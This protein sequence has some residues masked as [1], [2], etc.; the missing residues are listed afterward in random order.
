MP[1]VRD[2]TT[3]KIQP[4]EWRWPE[5]THHSEG[6]MDTVDSPPLAQPHR[7]YW[8]EYGN[9]KGEPVMFLHG[10]PGG[11]LTDSPS[12]ARFFDPQR[13]RIILFDQRGCCGSTPS[14]ADDPK[15]GLAN[16]DTQHLIADIYN[17]RAHL[18]I[19]T[20]M[21]VFGGSWG[22]TL[23]LAYAIAHPDTVESLILRGIFVGSTPAFDYL[24][25]GNAATY[26]TNPHDTSIPGAYLMYPE[27][28]GRYVET[29][30]PEKRGDIAKAYGEIFTTEPTND[31]ER[32]LQ[33]RAAINWAVWEGTC[34]YL[35]QDVEHD[36]ARFADPRFA[37]IF[38]MVENHYFLNGLFLGGRG[39]GNR[40]NLFILDNVATIKDI[41]IHIV[42][43]RYDQVCPLF[44]AENFVKALASVGAKPVTY[45][46]TAAGHSMTER[47]NA[48]AL[49]DIMEKLPRMKEF[50]KAA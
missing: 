34:S 13:Y 26:A 32:E 17:L 9:P 49:T 25:Q 41:P 1:Q 8:N 43:G 7:I 10:G 45:A 47:E 37:K 12:V 2:D 23:A 44:E 38:A 22:S 16:N 35:K 31:A 3:S 50:A 14:V 6:Y 19:T 21:H 28:W 27:T 33:Q 20:K 42:H 24:L 30:A 36:V 11:G 39:L 29:I 15:A 48:W 18:G 4:N 46:K 5:I 40:G